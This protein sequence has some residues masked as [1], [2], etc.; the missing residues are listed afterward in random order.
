MSVNDEIPSTPTNKSEI[1]QGGQ[2]PEAGWQIQQGH[3]TESQGQDAGKQ[4]TS[5][6]QNNLYATCAKGSSQ[7]QQPSLQP[8]RWLATIRKI[9]QPGM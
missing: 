6:Q 2:A 4:I 9:R 5:Q 7:Q 3:K 8:Y 1:P